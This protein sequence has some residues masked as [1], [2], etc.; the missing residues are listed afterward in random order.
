MEEN[1]VLSNAL[2][3]L[4]FFHHALRRG[5]KPFRI[6]TGWKGDPF[7]LNSFLC[8]KINNN[9]V[10]IEIHK[11]ERKHTNDEIKKMA[12]EPGGK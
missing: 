2:V 3:L 1:H 11:G 12:A 6:L 9:G 8:V 7:L 5:R 10:H 4:S